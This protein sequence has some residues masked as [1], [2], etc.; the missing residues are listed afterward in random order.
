MIFDTANPTGGDQD[1][2]FDSL[3]NVL[4][5]SEDSDS[6][7][8]DDALM[9]GT[10]RFEFDDLVNVESIGL[11]DIEEQGSTVTLFD[12]AGTAIS[13]IPIP[14]LTDNSFQQLAINV[15]QVAS[16]EVFFTGSGAVTDLIFLQPVI[17]SATV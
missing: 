14:A 11:L 4:I 9:G 13:T 3:G 10:L 2:A 5:I 15:D 16:V 12:E 1:L 17:A 8:P 7:D 6:S